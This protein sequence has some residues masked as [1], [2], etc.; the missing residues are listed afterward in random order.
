MRS[1]P[2]Q[3]ADGD[4]RAKRVRVTIPVAAAL[5]RWDVRTVRKAVESGRLA[6]GFEQRAQR[7]RWFVYADALPTAPTATQFGPGRTENESDSRLR[8]ENMALR[9]ANLL[10]LAANSALQEAS[11]AG[12][13]AALAK[14]ERH[15]IRAELDEASERHDHQLQRQLVSQDTALRALQDALVLFMT[16]HDP[17]G[18]TR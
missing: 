7:K 8:A 2:S 18:L 4:P 12:G 3:I 14:A 16:P 9:E 5:L 13:R 17:S 11:E 10:L 6:G 15:R 1:D